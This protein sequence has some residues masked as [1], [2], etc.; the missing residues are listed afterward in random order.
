MRARRSAADRGRR[1]RAAAFQAQQR[2]QE[3]HRGHAPDTGRFAVGGDTS[4]DHD[5]ARLHRLDA[6]RRRR[7][8]VRG[9]AAARTRASARLRRPTAARGSARGWARSRLGTAAPAAVTRP[10]A[11]ADRG[12]SRRSDGRPRSRIRRTRRVRRPAPGIG[13]GPAVRR[14]GEGRRVGHDEQRCRGRRPPRPALR[15]RRREVVGRLAGSLACEPG[16]RRCRR[17]VR[18]STGMRT[19]LA[20]AGADARERQLAHFGSSLRSSVLSEMPAREPAARKWAVEQRVV[21]GS[22]EPR[23][24][25]A[26]ERPGRGLRAERPRRSFGSASARAAAG[27]AAAEPEDRADA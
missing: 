14:F 26:G 25:G 19:T 16:G 2:A 22:R 17:R 13:V 5:V 9:R 24:V 21:L 4:G 11:A 8:A 7:S 20:P 3:P 1:A 18:Q 23:S 15:R 27:R 10:G 12:T 6:R